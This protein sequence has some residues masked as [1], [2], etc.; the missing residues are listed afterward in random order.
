MTSPKELNVYIGKI[1]IGKNGEVLKAILGSCI[2]IALIWKEKKKCGL[3]HC[4]LP[5]PPAQTFE[6]NGRFVSQAVPSLMALMKIQKE[7]ISSIEAVVAGGGNMFES[8]T[9]EPTESV[10]TLNSQAALKALK[11]VGIRVVFKSVGG[12]EGKKILV[13]CSNFTYQVEAIPRSDV[14]RGEKNGSS[15]SR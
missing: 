4:L 5:N 14:P 11:E 8:Q 10:G 15:K 7:D 6:I 9:G 12:D 3:A 2:G 1:R 13:D